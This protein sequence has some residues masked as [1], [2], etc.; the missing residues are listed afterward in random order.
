MGGSAL[1]ALSFARPLVVQG[2][3]GFWCTLTPRSVAQF[4]WAGWYGRGGG[5]DAGADA[6]VAELE[7]LLG[8]ATARDELGR[9]GRQLVVDRFSLESAAR[10]QVDCYRDALA[11]P[12]PPQTVA[13][14]EVTAGLRYTGYYLAKRIR[15]A[16]GTEQSEDFNARPVA[17]APAGAGDPVRVG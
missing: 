11:R 9:Y 7:P 14:Q 12:A 15:R 2:E 6:L 4:L 17:P 1:R 10:R 16:R 13:R 8:D 5:S 3:D